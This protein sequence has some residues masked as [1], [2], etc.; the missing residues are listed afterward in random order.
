M[1]PIRTSNLERG[2]WKSKCREQLLK[3]ICKTFPV[4][5]LTMANIT[6]ESK[7]GIAIKLLQVHLIPGVNDPYS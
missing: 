2:K 3:H 7:I 5:S 4:S 1:A 6:L